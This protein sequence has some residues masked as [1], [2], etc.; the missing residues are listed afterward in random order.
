MADRQ[1]K[2]NGQFVPGVSGNPKGRPRRP[3]E[4]LK[5]PAARRRAIF[6]VADT[7]V[8]LKRGDRLVGE[9]TMFEAAYRALG[10]AA[11]DGDR[12]AAKIF[13]DIAMKA[14]NE[15]AVRRVALHQ[16][17]EEIDAMAQEIERLKPKRQ[18]HGVF[19]TDPV[20]WNQL[21]A[22]IDDEDGMAAVLQSQGD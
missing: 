15:D 8:P 5:L 22:T 12:A 10:I 13:L 4:D 14:S 3:V 1:R 7:M 6:R 16:L 17:T 19:I 11:A 2:S 20:A 18:T 9:I 21:D